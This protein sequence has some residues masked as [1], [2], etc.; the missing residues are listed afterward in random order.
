MPRSSACA[1]LAPNLRLLVAVPHRELSTALAAMLRGFG[2]GQ[3]ETA[4]DSE[5]ALRLLKAHDYDAVVIDYALTPENGIG[6]TRHMRMTQA[7][8]NATTPVVMISADASRRHIEAARDAGI[9]EFLRLPV[10]P[11]ALS[12]RL[13]SAIANPRAFI[14][15]SAYSGPDRRRRIARPTPA[16]RRQP[17]KAG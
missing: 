7:C 12:D 8:R 9:H 13:C 2:I 6:L 17:S 10:S 15:A 5:A 16:E 14:R 4:H 11:E 3:I 1:S